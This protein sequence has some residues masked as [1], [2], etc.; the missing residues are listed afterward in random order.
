MR[1]LSLKP[2]LYTFDT[3]AAFAK[4]FHLGAG[5][6][7]FT[8]AFLY[9]PYMQ[10]LDLGCDVLFQ[11]QYGKGE[12]NDQM[13]DAVRA[14]MQK[15][16][17]RR[18]IAIGGGT[19]IDIAKV[20][21]LAD[22]TDT[23]A[24]FEG[25]ITPRRTVELVIVPTTCGTG[26]EVTALSIV[27]IRALHT[28]LGLRS[29]A[30]LPD[31]AVLIPELLRSLPYPFFVYSSIDALI[32]ATESYVSPNATPFTRLLSVQAMRMIL[33]GYRYMLDNGAEARADKLDDFLLASL[34]AGIAFG[35]AGV[36]AVHAL[37]YPL[38]GNYHVP[39][40]ESNYA[41]FTEVFRTYQ[42]LAPGGALAEANQ[43]LADILG[44]TADVVYEQLEQTLSGLLVR[45]PLRAYGMRREEI[46]AFT[47]SV[48]TTQQRLLKT[49][50]VP[51]DEAQIRAIYAALY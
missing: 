26:S 6:L 43:I 35:N 15:K 5:D 31:Q 38:G 19:V 33:G 10:P 13:I 11:E 45:K 49:S 8:N 24:L 20:I 29:D 40:G 37:S 4:E 18:I 32:H 14:D 41:F 44:C 28:K 42:R 16:A 48:L 36:G 22:V 27:E 25:K 7:L 23:Q 17:Y 50:Y 2:E 9:A 3:F 34:Y 47:Q 21:A 1:L 51:L 39:H 46:D 30:L 12:P